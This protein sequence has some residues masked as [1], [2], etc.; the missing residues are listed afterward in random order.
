MEPTVPN[1]PPTWHPACHLPWCRN[2]H[3]ATPVLSADVDVVHT[4]FVADFDLERNVVEIRYMQA[5]VAG[6]LQT[7]VLRVLYGSTWAV[8]DS[9]DIPLPAAGALGDI[10]ALLTVQTYAEFGAALTHGSKGP[11]QAKAVTW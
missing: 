6:A 11:G 5:Q 3:A 10:L 9:L 8:N 4:A 1:Q 2:D 7:P